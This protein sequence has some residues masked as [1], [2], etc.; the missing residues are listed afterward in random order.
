MVGFF[1]LFGVEHSDIEDVS[2]LMNASQLRM[3]G[4]R[5]GSFIAPPHLIADFLGSHRTPKSPSAMNVAP[6]DALC[7]N[8]TWVQFRLENVHYCSCY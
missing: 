8:L 4:G 6:K 5:A 3:S 7:S 2:S 1:W